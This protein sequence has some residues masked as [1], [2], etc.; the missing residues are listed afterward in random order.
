MC[1]IKGELLTV[2]DTLS[3]AS[4]HDTTPEIPEDELVLYTF[5]NYAILNE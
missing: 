5:N 3:R 1:Y 4:L 2:A